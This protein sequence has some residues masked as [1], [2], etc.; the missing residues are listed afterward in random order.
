MTALATTADVAA[1]LGRSLTAEEE[2]RAAKL[3]VLAS[4]AVLNRT[5]FRFLPGTYTI[6]RRPVDGQ[7]KIPA[8][9]AAL[10]SVTSVNQ[11]TGVGTLLTA[12]ADY[13]RRGRVLFGLDSYVKLEI[14]FTVSAAVPEEIVALVAGIVASTIA[15]PPVGASSEQAGPFVVSYVNSSGRVYLADSDKQILQPWVQPK[16]AADLL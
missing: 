11:R 1:S 13:T 6:T 10:T 16:L 14:V 2:G 3:L 8:T 5:R 4:K 9:I 7:I 12:D 15:G